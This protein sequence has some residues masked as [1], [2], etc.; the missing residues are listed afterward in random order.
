[1]HAVIVNRF[2]CQRCRGLSDSNNLPLGQALKVDPLKLISSDPSA[3]WQ[4]YSGLQTAVDASSLNISI[5]QG[6]VFDLWSGKAWGNTIKFSITTFWLGNTFGDWLFNSASCNRLAA[7]RSFVF[8]IQRETFPVCSPR[9]P[10]SLKWQTS[11]M[12]GGSASAIDYP[13]LAREVNYHLGECE[14]TISYCHRTLDVQCLH[15]SSS[16]GTWWLLHRAR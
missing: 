10:I 8:G 2:T 12:D 4:R 11:A 3:C 16:C 6:T 1:M 15:L 5:E 13:S 14:C 7:C 9:V